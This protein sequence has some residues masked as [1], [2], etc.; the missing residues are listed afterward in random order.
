MVRMFSFLMTLL[1]VPPMHHA[2]ATPRAAIVQHM[3]ADSALDAFN[4]QYLHACQTMDQVASA[5]FWADDGVDLIA[6]LQPM[7]GKPAIRAWLEGLAVATRGAKMDSCTIDWRDQKI[8][9]DV[10]Y[11]WGITRQ[12]ITLPPPHDPAV[13]AGKI[14]LILRRQHGGAWKIELESWNGLPA[15]AT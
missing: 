8:D 12:H 5:E 13:S 9:G 11:E 1:L 15:N 7:V 4:V 6:G 3:L 10:A 2:P 14:V